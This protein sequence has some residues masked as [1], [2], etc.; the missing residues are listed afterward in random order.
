M[1]ENQYQVSEIQESHRLDQL[2]KYNILDS[3]SEAEYNDIARLAS[4]ICETPVA[5]IN[6]IDANRQ[7][8]KSAVG[9]DVSEAPRMHA[10]C[11]YAIM[12]PDELMIVED[13]SKDS[14]F[15]DHP[16]IEA[17]PALAFYAGMPLTNM[18]GY[19]LGT[20]CVLDTKPR[21]LT[22]KQTKAL[23]L[24]SIQLI[25][26]LEMRRIN[27][28]HESLQ[29][30][31]HDHDPVADRHVQLVTSQIRESL[32]DVVSERAQWDD[33]YHT[34]VNPLPASDRTMEQMEVNIKALIEK[35]LSHYPE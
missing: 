18:Y 26:M 35:I 28:E 6:F 23:K 32:Q 4:S 25:H 20:I 7:W 24:F 5:C 31:L 34:D 14:R 3:V 21:T 27:H 16:I 10:V 13:F 9:I 29:A 22:A 11:H 17:E 8:V 30:K 12:H 1:M 15:Q 33:W 19:A 2:Y